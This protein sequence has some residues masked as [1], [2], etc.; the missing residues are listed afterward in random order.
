MKMVNVENGNVRMIL[1]EGKEEQHNYAQ[2]SNQEQ[3][4]KKIVWTEFITV[5]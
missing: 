1:K 5:L 3:Y 4:S 2:Y